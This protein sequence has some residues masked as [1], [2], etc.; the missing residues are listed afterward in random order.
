MRRRRP[1]LA[2]LVAATVVIGLGAAPVAFALSGSSN[3]GA[4]DLLLPTG[5]R[6]L[7]MGQAAVALRDGAEGIWWNPAVIARAHRE[8]SFHFAQTIATEGDYTLAVLVPVE[9]VGALAISA[10]YIDYGTQSV[11]GKTDPTEVGV[12]STTSTIIS[13]S[14]AAPFGDRLGAGLT[15]KLYTLRL[16]CSGQCLNTPPRSPAT[17]AFDVGMQ[18][19]LRKDSSISLGAAVRNLGRPLQVRDSPQADPLPKRADVGVAFAPRF[20]QLPPNAR[21]LLSADV[22]TRLAGGGPGYR[23]GGELSWEGK[24]QL[25]AGYV[26]NGPTGNN[27]SIGLGYA[28][29]RLQF[30]VAQLITQGS[31]S[32]DQTP[33]FFSVR[34]I[35]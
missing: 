27:G 7:G 6:A 30:D 12:F 11:T 32:S 1:K 3:E 8:A 19:V 4:F 22:V 14:V 17:Y 9:Y 10:R 16:P 31:S 23:I 24:Y 28:T 15:Y 20:Q 21:V 5:A 25:R 2:R 33:F 18:Y 13:A 29:R 26:I 35:F 34:Y